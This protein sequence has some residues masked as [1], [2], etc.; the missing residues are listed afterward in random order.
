MDNNLSA[1]LQASIAQKISTGVLAMAISKEL[2]SGQHGLAAMTA[3]AGAN[4]VCI[5]NQGAL[6]ITCK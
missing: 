6:N 4:W 2:D 5:I 3:M 1:D